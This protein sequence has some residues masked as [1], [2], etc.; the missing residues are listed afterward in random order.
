MGN[1]TT[2]ATGALII[3]DGRVVLSIEGNTELKYSM[4]SGL[5]VETF[6]P[7]IT[8]NFRPETILINEV[9][10]T[11]GVD[12]RHSAS[13][14]KIIK[15]EITIKTT[16]NFK[17]NLKL[18]VYKINSTYTFNVKDSNTSSIM[19]LSV[20]QIT[21]QV[22]NNTL[23]LSFCAKH[24]LKYLCTCRNLKNFKGNLS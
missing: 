7:E 11:L 4:V 5:S 8:G 1:R 13:I 6:I 3:P 19:F 10:T 23:N 12:L 21:K 16:T 24:M 14:N 15:S 9:K 22:L 18:Y 17:R 2:Y 20:G